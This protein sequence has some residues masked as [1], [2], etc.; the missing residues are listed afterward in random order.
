M[1]SRLA[2]GQGDP[3]SPQH[4]EQ[5]LRFPLGLASRL[6]FREPRAVVPLCEVALVFDLSD[7]HSGLQRDAVTFAE[8]VEDPVPV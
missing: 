2:L 8:G 5:R 3:P 7:A 4:G 6:A 1:R